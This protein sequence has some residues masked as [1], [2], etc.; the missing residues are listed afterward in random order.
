MKNSVSHDDLSVFLTVVREGGFR[1]ASRQLGLAPSKV[2]TTISR[3][4]AS[5]GLPLLIR[6]TRSVRMTEAG[7]ALAERI[8]PH[9]A[10]LDAACAET[11]GAAG[12]VR[13]RLKLNVPGAVMPDI[14]PRLLAA[15]HS[16]HPEVETEIVVENRLVDIVAAGCDAGIRYGDVVAK[17]MVSIPIGPRTQQIALA[18]APGYLEA[19]GTPRAPADLA[20]HD[21]IR[22]RLPGGPFLPWTLRDGAR[23][24]TVEP[25]TRLV[26]SVDALDTGRAYARAGI[27]IIGA[28]HN[29]L[30][31]DF[32]TGS[33]VP[34]LP[35]LWQRM[36]GP[37]LY[38]PSRFGSPALRAF[39]E[40]CRNGIDGNA[41]PDMPGPI[42]TEPP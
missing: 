39:I 42:R 3:I 11:A 27:G 32:A 7:E 34:V 14:L 26:L 22:Y 41:P 16:R 12:R 19:H 10:G 1:A 25:V 17:D 36:D 24:I 29:W 9:L 18:A 28:F 21:A 8:A 38:Y 20:R 30:R 33:L 4:E 5:L 23:T 31:A 37:R 6:T 40:F 2:S 13:G 35:D 15:F